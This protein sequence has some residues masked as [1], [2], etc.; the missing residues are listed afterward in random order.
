MRIAFYAPMKPPTASQPSGDRHMARALMAALRFAGHEVDLASVFRSRDGDGD[1]DR[2]L[3]LRNI[4]RQIAT[5]LIRRYQSGFADRPDLWFTYHVYYKAPDWIGPVVSEALGVPYVI[6]EASHAPKRQD[7]PWAIGYEGAAAAIRTADRIV[8]INSSN[9]PCVLPLLRD[10][11]CVIPLRP[12]LDTR[13]FDAVLH[14]TSKPA[15]NPDA[16]LLITTAMMRRGD[17]LASYRVLAEALTRLVALP[18]RLVVI[19]D[20]AARAEIQT[21]MQPLGE[22]R[23]SFLGERETSE[24][25]DLLN[26]ADLF[27]W[28]AVREAYGMAIL[29]AQAA[30]LP[31]VA[32]NAG[33]VAEIVRHGVTGL[34]TPEGNAAA[35][36]DAVAALLA[37]SARREAMA[38][39]ALKSV[40]NDHS[41]E[42]ASK[43]LD[44]VL[45]TARQRR[46]A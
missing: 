24:L 43:V 12:F 46:A 18:W 14:K 29:E 9:L 39:A 36:A 31:V 27:L 2:Q 38:V 4:G 40:A 25:P 33:G 32:G 16:P 19:G 42:A 11:G 3:R 15:R 30:G 22:N 28:P 26:T 21:L 44:E 23:V 45:M 10:P 20:G 1:E 34:L 13:P 6:A 37:D 5:R 41:L 17:K 35:F 8:G 7:G